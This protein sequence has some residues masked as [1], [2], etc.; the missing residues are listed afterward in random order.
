MNLSQDTK[1][2]IKSTFLFIYTALRTMLATLLTIFVYQLC[3]NSDGTVKDCTFKDNFIDLTLFNL[4]AVIINFLTLGI[5]IGFYILEYYREHKCIKY[6]DIDCNM[7]TNNLKYE[8]I[9]YPKIEKKLNA[10]NVHYR[11]YSF[12]MFLVNILNIVVSSIVIYHYY[13][14]YKSIVGMLSETFLIVDK[15][16]N[17]LNIAYKSVKEILPYSAYMKDYIIFNTIDLKYKHKKMIGME[18]VFE[19]ELKQIQIEE[20][21]KKD[22]DNSNLV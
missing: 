8:I 16:Y 19:I 22:E 1:Q 3:S 12:V 13:G 7:P 2:Q 4:S 20:E 6:L 15:L 10:L 18:N 11:N 21:K 9:S 17:S 5:F 14:G